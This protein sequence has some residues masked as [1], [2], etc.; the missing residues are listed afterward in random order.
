[1]RRSLSIDD[2]REVSFVFSIG[3]RFLSYVTGLVLLLA[4]VVILLTVDFSPPELPETELGTLGARTYY[5]SLRELSESERGE[6]TEIVL[7]PQETSYLMEQYRP[8]DSYY[9]FQLVDSH[10]Q[11]QGNQVKIRGGVRGPAGVY[12]LMTY[13]G[14]I[15]A[16][17]ERWVFQPQSVLVGQLPVSWLVPSSWTTT[18]SNQWAGGTVEVREARLNGRGL[19]ATVVNRGLQLELSLGLLEQFQ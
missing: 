4:G 5:L 11:A 9:G 1:M 2:P 17:G 15:R 8:E 18:L 7:S 10:L 3:W 19:K 12:L 14:T 6:S 13:V 16:E